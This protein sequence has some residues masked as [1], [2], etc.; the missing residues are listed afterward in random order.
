MRRFYPSIWIAIL[1]TSFISKPSVASDVTVGAIN[2]NVSGEARFSGEATSFMIGKFPFTQGEHLDLPALNEYNSNLLDFFRSQGF[3]LTE[4]DSRLLISTHNS[5]ADIYISI[6][7]KETYQFAGFSYDDNIW[8][9]FKF[10]T[11]VEHNL[12]KDERLDTVELERFYQ[13]LRSEMLQHSIENKIVFVWSFEQLTEEHFNQ[14]S[15]E[16]KVD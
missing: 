1:I 4:I 8:K 15:F 11:A 9:K 16:V 12:H 5:V 6:D 10:L 7:S 13:A 2:L 14:A 3:L